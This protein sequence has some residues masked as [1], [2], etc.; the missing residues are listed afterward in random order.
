LLLMPCPFTLGKGGRG[1]GIEEEK[2]GGG[3][4]PNRKFVKLGEKE[5]PKLS[6]NAF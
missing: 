2:G 5:N 3:R 1:E 6:Y 4:E